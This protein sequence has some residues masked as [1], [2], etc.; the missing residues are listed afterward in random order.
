MLVDSVEESGPAYAGG[1]RTGDVV[2]TIDGQ[3]LTVRFT[4]EV[5][6]LLKK[7]AEKKNVQLGPEEVVPRMGRPP[8]KKK[9]AIAEVIYFDEDS[10][11]ITIMV[12]PK[13]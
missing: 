7:I 6:P 5:P 1:L 13:E 2:L 3:P 9:G 10:G 11:A 4:E 8:K 12:K